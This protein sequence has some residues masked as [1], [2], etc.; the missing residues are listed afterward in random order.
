MDIQV[1]R[2]QLERVV[3]KWLNQHFSNLTPKKHKNISS[4]LFYVN[5]NNEVIIEYIP[6][7]GFVWINYKNIWSKLESIFHLNEEDARLFLKVWL[8]ETYDLDDVS[9]QMDRVNTHL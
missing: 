7:N 4:K 6:K 5:S 2:H 3:I 1:N 8:R 9:P